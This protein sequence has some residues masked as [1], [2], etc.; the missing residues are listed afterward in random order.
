MTVHHH[1]LMIVVCAK[2]KNSH[3]SCSLSSTGNGYATSSVQERKLLRSP[4]RD[5]EQDGIIEATMQ[6]Q[7]HKHARIRSNL[8]RVEV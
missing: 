6:Q 8:G 3:G 7:D 5:E 4:H 1:G 2:E